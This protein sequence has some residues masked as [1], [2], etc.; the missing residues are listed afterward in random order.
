M[1]ENY[2]QYIRGWFGKWASFYNF[3]ALPLTGVRN[4][5]TDMIDSRDK[6]KIL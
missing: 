3:I 4:K 6:L 1:D 2:Y 5:V